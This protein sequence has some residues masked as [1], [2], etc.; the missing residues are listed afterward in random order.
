MSGRQNKRAVHGILL[1]DKAV[2]ISSNKALQQVKY[3]FAAEKA[4]HTGSLDPLASGMLPICFGEAT[5]FSHYL[6]N[7]DKHY[8]VIAKLG[9]KTTT[10]DAEGDVVAAIKPRH[11]SMQELTSQLQNFKGKQL[12]IPS[13]F[14]ALKHQGQPLYK[15][16]RKGLEVERKAREIQVY[17]LD[18]LSYKADE[19]SLLVHCSKGTYIRNLVE[20]IGEALGCGAHVS[21]LRRLQVNNYPA[22]NM[23]SFAELE[24]A[25][26]QHGLSALDKLLLPIDYPI[27]QWP[28][29]RLTPELA[30]F[31][32]QGQTIALP[33]PLTYSWVRL[34][35]EE[36]HF[37]GVGEIIA[38]QSV[39]P[40]R[41]VNLRT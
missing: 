37:L 36:G 33:E 12:Q 39:A 27:M 8:Q 19:M 2:G 15:L 11:F 21:L 5:K 38:E 41:L 24:Q 16:A 4:G 20:D 30:K 22:A 6:L 32:Q 29:V 28:A 1:L 17:S 3:L 34:V 40:R 26:A 23:L 35:T 13:M 31:I 14:S 25:H 9:V 7:A 10:G 18:L